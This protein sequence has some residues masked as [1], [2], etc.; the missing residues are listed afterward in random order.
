[1]PAGRA[2]ATT[3]GAKAGNQTYELA[4]PAGKMYRVLYARV[5]L[6]TDATV[7]NRNI[8]FSVRNNAG[9]ILAYFPASNNITA[10]Q[11]AYASFAPFHYSLGAATPD[12]A[13]I[14]ATDV[15]IPYYTKFVISILG[16]LAGDSFSVY[17]CYLECDIP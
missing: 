11:T 5:T 6:T 3:S 17:I 15:W 10:S 8:A 2:V 9:N 7:G 13:L 12:N 4:P 16:G 14:A 1:M